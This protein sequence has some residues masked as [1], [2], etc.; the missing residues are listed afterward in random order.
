VA[1]LGYARISTAEQDLA[2]QRRA[3]LAAGCTE[4][5]AETASGA[6]RG[7]P[8]L[9]RLLERLRPGDTL[10]VVRIDRLAR[11]LAHLLDVI[12]RLE[13]RGAK[14]RSLGDP[15][16]TAGPSGTLIL[17][18]LGAVAEFER[19]L[20]RE[21][22]LA[23]LA[24]ARAQGRIGGNPQLRARDPTALA[25]LAVARQAARLAAALPEAEFWLPQ[26]RRLRPAASWAA[27]AGRINAGLPVGR[28]PFTPERLVRLARLFVRE[29]LLEPGVMKAAT[30]PPGRE[31]ARASRAVELAAAYLRGRPDASLAEL[32]AQLVR[33]GVHPPRGGTAWAPSSLK[34][35]RDGAHQAGLLGA[36]MPR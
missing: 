36:A 23:G 15:I 5:V 35:L 3:L 32:G 21:R 27:V 1:T 22:T 16:D 11:S 17:Q 4:I 25:R 8:E 30:K 14:F 18:I 20:I 24:A 26:V 12:G 13:A 9:A 7:R 33:L 2:P 34:A 10:V 19:A 29:G 31:K 28:K 6:D